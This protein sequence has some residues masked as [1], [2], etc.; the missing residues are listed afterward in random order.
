MGK[1][2]EDLTE[3]GHARFGPTLWGIVLLAGQSNSPHCREALE[4]LCATY[5]APIHAFLLRK[6]YAR[7][8]A[9]D[10]TQEFFAKLLEKNF[11]SGVDPIKGKF[12]TFLLKCLNHFLA[13]EWDKARAEKRGGKCIFVSLD[14]QSADGQYLLEPVSSTLNPEEHFDFRWALTVFAK[15]DREFKAECEAKG[16]ADL[17]KELRVYMSSPPQGGDYDAVG[18]RLHMTNNAVSKEVHSMRKRYFNLVREEVGH[19][20]S[21]PA[22]IEDELRYL[23]N[24]LFK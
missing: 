15:V 1:A 16:K 19:T 13:N 6:G 11:L 10:L 23:L 5:W 22:E 12:R 14:E 2:G 24:M 18:A 3:P 20:L 8:D 9:K 17:Y 21:N 7:E 4:S